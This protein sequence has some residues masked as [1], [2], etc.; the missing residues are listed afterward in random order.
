MPSKQSP[1]KKRAFSSCQMLYLHTSQATAQQ[2]AFNLQ[3]MRSTCALQNSQ[4][5]RKWLFT[6]EALNAVH[7]FSLG[8]VAGLAFISG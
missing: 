8:K 6:H 2:K 1:H 7:G 4:L 5:K 3:A